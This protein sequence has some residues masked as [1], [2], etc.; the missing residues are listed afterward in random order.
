MVLFVY[1]LV[2]L[3]DIGFD[4]LPDLPIDLGIFIPDH[5]PMQVPPLLPPDKV[6]LLSLSLDHY[7][8]VGL[9]KVHL[10]D[11]LTRKVSHDPVGMIAMRDL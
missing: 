10:I 8:L 2:I 1:L 9:D 5:L 6:E 4:L 3:P 11:P 7:I